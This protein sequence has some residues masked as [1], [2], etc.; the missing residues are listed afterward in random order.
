MLRPPVRPNDRVDKRR[1]LY[2]TREDEETWAEAAFYCRTLSVS[3]SSLAATALK[4]Y[5][6]R[7][8][9]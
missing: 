9:T 7:H 3:L 8:R 6:E 4:E 5:L 1:T 2:V